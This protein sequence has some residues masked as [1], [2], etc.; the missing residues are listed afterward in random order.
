MSRTGATGTVTATFT[1]PQRHG[2]V[3]PAPLLELARGL[4]IVGDANAAVDSPRQV[5][6][7]A[8]EVEAGLG[9]APGALWENITTSGVDIDR[10][11]SGSLLQIGAEAVVALTYACRPCRVITDATGVSLRRLTGQRGMVAVVTGSGAVAPGDPVTVLPRRLPP[12]PEPYLE[13]LRLVVAGIPAGAVLTHDSLVVA[14]GAPGSLRRIL[15]RWLSQLGEEGLPSHRA[16]ASL[17]ARLEPAQERRLV[18]EGV[19]VRDGR[20]ADPPSRWSAEDFLRRR[21][22]G[23]GPMIPVDNLLS[24]GVQE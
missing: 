9:L 16:V 11:P 17:G 14:V 20:L 13:R 4:G 3:V 2:P 24:P 21:W 7:V 1:K 8:E 22:P 5:L 15:P 19:G 10:L 6:V 18:E 12:L 23:G